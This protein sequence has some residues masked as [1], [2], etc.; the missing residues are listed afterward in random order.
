M[1]T[2]N[3]ENRVIIITLNTDATALGE[4][5]ESEAVGYVTSNE[6]AENYIAKEE[7]EDYMN[8]SKNR[9]FVWYEVVQL[10]GA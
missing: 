9:Y 3:E 2:K 4:S 5:D 10:E 7:V 8:D 1:T 6:E